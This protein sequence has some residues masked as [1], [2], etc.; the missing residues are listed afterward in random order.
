MQAIDTNVLVRY[1]TSDD[2]YQ[3]TLATKFIETGEAKLVN[4][5]VLV[6]LLWVLSSVYKL[7]RED[8][9]DV[10]A[11]IANSGFFRFAQDNAVRSAISRFASGFDLPDAFIASMNSAD[12][13]S[14]TITF[15]KKASRLRGFSLLRES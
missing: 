3:A 11:D 10:M 1:L 15:D 6:E 13:A 4:P 2:E 9:A 14:E 8:I 12:G 5:I 7:S